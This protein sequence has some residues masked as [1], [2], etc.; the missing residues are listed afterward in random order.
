MRLETI[1]NKCLFSLQLELT[2]KLN[3]LPIV[4]LP[5]VK[6]QPW[7]LVIRYQSN[8]IVVGNLL[9]MSW[10]EV[11]AFLKDMYINVRSAAFKDKSVMRNL[12]C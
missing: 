10:E 9:L 5:Y 3:N 6:E 8:G 1:V 11:D 4:E 12:L 2:E 7:N